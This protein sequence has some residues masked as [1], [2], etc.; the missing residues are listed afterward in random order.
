[1]NDRTSRDDM[2]ELVALYALGVLPREE[3]ALTAAFL[4]N[5]E[6]AR[7]EYLAL[8]A[9][10]DALAYSAEEPVDSAR[11]ARMKERL[12]ARVRNEPPNG[13][14]ARRRIG[15]NAGWLWAAALATAASFLLAIISSVQ[16]S[17]LQGQLAQANR[18]N[19]VL[20]TQVAQAQHDAQRD[21]QML[22]DLSSRDARRYEVAQGGVV[23]RGERIYLTLSKLPP[24]PK[25]KVYQAWT[26]PKGAKAV[27]P[28]LTFS[29][30]A[31]GVAVVAL[32]VDASKVGA[33]AVSVEPEGGSKTPTTTP[34]FVRPIS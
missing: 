10:A 30:N 9:S 11:S 1:M 27:Q 8:R 5:D 23:V 19:G 13:L 29:P 2:M 22:T 17:S 20:S 6:A 25:G 15:P 31:D 4:A 3:A 21:R 14:I 34:T 18:R 12:L 24:L 33:V 16:V 7:A 32:P 26:L 28:S